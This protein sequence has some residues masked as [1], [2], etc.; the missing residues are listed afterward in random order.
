MD[1]INSDNVERQ[2]FHKARYQ[3]VYYLKRKNDPDFQAKR[4]E[5]S[6]RNYSY[7]RQTIDC[8]SCQMRHRPDSDTCLAVEN[9]KKAQAMGDV[10]Q[11]V[12]SLHNASSVSSQND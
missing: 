7:R 8:N 10:I 11:L 2:K 4:K 1:N 12:S 6:K 9:A 3:R 5:A